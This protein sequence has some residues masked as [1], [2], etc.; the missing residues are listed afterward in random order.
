M[1]TISCNDYIHMNFL[2][3]RRKCPFHFRSVLLYASEAIPFLL[4][5]DIT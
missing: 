4:L 3:T 2:L 5:W 1:N